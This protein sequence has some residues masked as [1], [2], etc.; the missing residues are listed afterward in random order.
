MKEKGLKE[1][2]KY[3]ITTVLFVIKYDWRVTDRLRVLYYLVI[4][5]IN[6]LGCLETLRRVR[7]SKPIK[8]STDP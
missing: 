2:E 5:C 8:T 6:D 3:K 4:I 1:R 7:S